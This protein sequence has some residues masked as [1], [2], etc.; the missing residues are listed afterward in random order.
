MNIKEIEQREI[1]FLEEY[2]LEIK[3]DGQYF[4]GIFE[5]DKE[6]K[7]LGSILEEFL[8]ISSCSFTTASHNVKENKRYSDIGKVLLF[9]RCSLLF[10]TPLMA[11]HIIW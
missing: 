1:S 3:R 4:Y 6:G 11:L 10:V 7:S 2:F 5:A 9:C 8:C